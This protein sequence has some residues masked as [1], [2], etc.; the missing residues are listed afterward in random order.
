MDSFPEIIPTERLK[1][2]DVPRP[3]EPWRKLSRFALTF[4]P[5]EARDY[6]AA[7][8]D[9]SRASS[10]LSLAELRAHLYVEQRRWNHFGDEPDASTMRKL[11]EIVRL[12][13]AKLQP[14]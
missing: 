4:D 7:A 3:E 11:R 5:V 13:H 6:G 1:P 14:D 8:G 2:D 10:R 9:L 12:I